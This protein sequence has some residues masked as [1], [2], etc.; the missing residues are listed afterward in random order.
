MIQKVP[1]RCR[2]GSS[3]DEG[4]EDGEG[5]SREA[6]NKQLRLQR[7]QSYRHSTSARDAA[8]KASYER[9]TVHLRMSTYLPVVNDILEGEH[10]LCWQYARSNVT[11]VSASFC[12]WGVFP[13]MNVALYLHS[14]KRERR[15]KKSQGRSIDAAT[16]VASYAGGLNGLPIRNLT[17]GALCA[18]HSHA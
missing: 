14:R 18:G 8:F 15:Y 10:T 5:G 6:A 4:V 2:V 13:A 1:R 3:S 11:P 17:M 7:G 12:S 9:V 16:G